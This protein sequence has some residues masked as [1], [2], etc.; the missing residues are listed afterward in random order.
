MWE[1]ATPISTCSGTTPW[2]PFKLSY[3]AEFSPGASESCKYKSEISTRDGA[4][5]TRAL[6]TNGD[7]GRC[8]P[9][10]YRVEILTA[11]T[12]ERWVR[13][14]NVRRELAEFKQF[15]FSAAGGELLPVFAAEI[16]GLSLIADHGLPK[17]KE[18]FTESCRTRKTANLET[19]FDNLLAAGGAIYFYRDTARSADGDRTAIR[20]AYTYEVKVG[21]EWRVTPFLI[22][23]TPVKVIR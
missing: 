19:T 11:M 21:D 13:M 1:P 14:S 20:E 2:D 16:P 15:V 9:L 23:L 22:R 3:A 8:T 4:E 10:R 18:A 6:M 7:F 12:K 17:L 5:A